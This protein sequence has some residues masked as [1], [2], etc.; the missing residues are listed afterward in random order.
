MAYRT[1][2]G[3]IS[4]DGGDTP[5]DFTRGRSKLLALT[6]SMQ[7]SHAVAA[8]QLRKV[9]RAGKGVVPVEILYVYEYAILPITTLHDVQTQWDTIE[10][11]FMTHQTGTLTTFGV[12]DYSDTISGPVRIEDFDIVNDDVNYKVLNVHFFSEI[13]MS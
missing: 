7:S 13:G 6:R 1:G 3:L 2:S 8:G 4:Y 11:Y 12:G 5:V 9:D 10:D